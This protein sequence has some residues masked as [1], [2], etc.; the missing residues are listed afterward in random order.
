MGTATGQAIRLAY[1]VEGAGTPVVFLHGLTFDRR[2]WR[3]IVERLG[4]SVPSGIR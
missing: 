3:P 1:E 2:T 4:G